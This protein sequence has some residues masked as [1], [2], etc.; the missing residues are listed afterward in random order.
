MSEG[1]V[2]PLKGSDIDQPDR[3][4]VAALLEREERLELFDKPPEVHQARLRVA[5]HPVRQVGDELFEIL[6]DAADRRVARGELLPHLVHALGKPGRNR[7]NGVLLGLLPEP[8]VLQ[9]DV[10]DGVE[11]R[12]FLMSCQVT[13]LAH[14]LM[15]F[16]PRG[17]RF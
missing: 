8:L 15:E 2:V 14:P 9:E 6:R 10:V 13:L 11:Q 4:P 12:V 3:A 7:L 5:V 17:R 16:R 1:V